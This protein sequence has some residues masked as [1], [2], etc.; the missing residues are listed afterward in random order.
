MSSTSEIAIPLPLEVWQDPQGNVVLHH[1]REGCS[2]YFGCW[3]EAGEPAD[4]LCRLTFHHAWAVRGF[5]LECLPYRAQEHNYRSYIYR[6]EGS[7]WL[8]Q[9]S[10]QRQACY[11]EWKR[12]DGREYLHYVV[13]GHD[14]Y[15]DVI[16]AGYNA[17]IIPEGE[18]GEM[19]RLIREA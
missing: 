4:Y 5:N 6:V 14:N 16:A 12:W 8:E 19:V 17:Q 9:V 3:A 18:A 10:E 15:Y 7:A 13:S 1:S 2:V 11:P